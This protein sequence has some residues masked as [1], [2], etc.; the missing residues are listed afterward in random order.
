MNDDPLKLQEV[1]FQTMCN[2]SMNEDFHET[3]E[4]VVQTIPTSDFAAQNG[5]WHPTK[6]RTITL[7]LKV[8]PKDGGVN[9]AYD[10]STKIPH[11]SRSR[12]GHVHLDEDGKLY[13]FP[14]RQAELPLG[15]V[16][17]IKKKGE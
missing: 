11:R 14:A 13:Q 5:P 15:T 1:N 17:P 12:G 2:G 3:L 10:I 8:E 9:I 4:Q 16:T 6:A 7:T